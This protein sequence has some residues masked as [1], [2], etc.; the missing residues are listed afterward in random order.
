MLTQAFNLLCSLCSEWAILTRSPGVPWPRTSWSRTWPWRKWSMP[1]SRRTAGWRTTK[2]TP[3]AP[4]TSHLSIIP[5]YSTQ[6]LDNFKT[7]ENRSPLAWIC[8]LYKREKPH[9]G[10]PNGS[11]VSRSASSSPHFIFAVKLPAPKLLRI[12]VQ[13]LLLP[14]KTPSSF[15]SFYTSSFFRSCCF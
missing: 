2:W 11:H 14:L 8:T 9:Y 4:P 6:S 13:G 15:C 10:L 12:G 3:P 5:R 7:P 1:L